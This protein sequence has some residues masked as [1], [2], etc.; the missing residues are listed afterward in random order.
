MTRASTLAEAFAEV[1]AMQAPLNARLA[2]YAD[3]LRELNFPFAE[4]YDDLVARLFSGEVGNM[5][6]E[7]GAALPQFVLPD[8][9]GLLVSLEELT[10]QGPVI[11]SLNRGHWCPFC[12]ITL[13]TIAEHNDEIAKT[14]AQVVSII[15]DRQQFTDDLRRTTQHN[16]RILTDVDC[17]YALSLGLVVWVGEHLKTLMKGRGYH[18]D[19][20]H[21]N[22]GWFLPAPATFVVD[23]DARIIGRFVDP[24]F[25]KRMEVDDI[26]SILTRFRSDR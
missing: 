22:D 6:P 16:I 3:K 11:L 20:Y 9:S 13:R 8:R 15:P 2:A 10:K 5:V 1:C 25:R 4:A 17:G 23:G 26:L 18:L 12:R 19:T 21:G 14:G 24:D 7:L